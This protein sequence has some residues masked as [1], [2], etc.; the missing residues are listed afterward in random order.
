M[1]GGKAVL[2]ATTWDAMSTTMRSTL[3][4]GISVVLFGAGCWAWASPR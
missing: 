1:F 2:L 3:L 4:G